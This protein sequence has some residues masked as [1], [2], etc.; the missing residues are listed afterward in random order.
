MDYIFIYVLVIVFVSTFVRAAFG[1]GNALIAM[2]LLAFVL[3]IKTT[4]AVVALIALVIAVI[5]LLQEWREVHLASAWRLVVFSFLGIPLGLFMLKGMY[6]GLLKGALAI[7]II[8]FAIYFLFRPKLYTLKT[9]RSAFLFG[10]IAGILVAA[11][12][13]NGPVIVMYGT[14]RRWH[15]VQ[16]RAT[17]QGYFLPT[18]LMVVLGHGYAG[19]W[20]KEV[21]QYLFFSLPVVLLSIWMGS[22][23]NRT[24]PD[25]KFRMT[26]YIL[27]IVAGVLLL[28]QSLF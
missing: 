10:F 15:P 20:T 21:F 24:M 5:I 23:L 8:L 17:L 18:T 11:Y 22:R 12:N 28:M 25:E 13:T 3:D 26:I 19:F 4:T 14:M 1:F 9:D 2:P 27:L 16:F 7:F 6:E